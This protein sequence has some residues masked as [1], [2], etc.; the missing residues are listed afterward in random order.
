MLIYINY[1]DVTSNIEFDRNSKRWPVKYSHFKCNGLEQKVVNCYHKISNNANDCKKN[2]KYYYATTSCE[3]TNGKCF[4][5]SDS[6]F[7]FY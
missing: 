6:N 3:S 1:S 7:H 2:N 5:S 4:V